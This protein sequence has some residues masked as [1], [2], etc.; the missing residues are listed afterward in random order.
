MQTSRVNKSGCQINTITLVFIDHIWTLT[1][2][3]LEQHEH[4]YNFHSGFLQERENQSLISK[5][6]LYKRRYGSI[7]LHTHPVS[8]ML[9][10]EWFSFIIL[11]TF[12]LL[13]S[14]T[15]SPSHIKNMKVTLEAEE[16]QK[17]INDLCDLNADLQVGLNLVYSLMIGLLCKQTN[18]HLA[19]SLVNVFLQT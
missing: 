13:P 11:I 6:L 5:L 14:S 19:L 4:F 10:T 1:Y 18:K 17:K 12:S 3:L 8:D 2:T 16:L 9:Y 7:H 15:F